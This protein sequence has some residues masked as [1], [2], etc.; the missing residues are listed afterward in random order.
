MRH[1]LR[2][3]YGL[4]FLT[5]PFAGMWFV[6]QFLSA[7]MAPCPPPCRELSRVSNPWLPV[8]AVIAERLSGATVAT[9]TLVFVV[10]K[11][12]PI[13]DNG[14]FLCDHARGVNV[15]WT[16]ANRLEVSAESARV[17]QEDK[18]YRAPLA[19]SRSAVGSVVYRIEHRE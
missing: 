6:G 15:A 2:N 3:S 10:S 13:P 5:I 19:H 1:L 8:D 17:F 14:A 9:P 4:V 7:L 12:E 18:I 16:A 11:G